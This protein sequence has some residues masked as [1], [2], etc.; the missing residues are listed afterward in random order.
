MRIEDVKTLTDLD[1]FLSNQCGVPYSSHGK[2][3]P[4]GTTYANRRAIVRL[5]IETHI[6][7]AKRQK[8]KPRITIKMIADML[9]RL[10]RKYVLKTDQISRS[11]GSFYRRGELERY[12]SN[13]RRVS[14]DGTIYRS[15]RQ[16]AERKQKPIRTVTNRIESRNPDF[17]GWKYTDG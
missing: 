9:E 10:D 14:I 16:A 17:Q 5:F 2:K 15:I 12:S 11:L 8:I 7:D 6:A 3:T 4:D 13:S 1:I